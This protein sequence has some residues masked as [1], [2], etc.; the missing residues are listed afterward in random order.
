MQHPV[1]KNFFLA[2][3]A[4]D[5]RGESVTINCDLHTDARA[6]KAIEDAIIGR[7]KSIL[8]HK[9]LWNYALDNDQVTTG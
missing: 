9:A 8:H 7:S 2:D 4:A 3:D 6:V 5:G 1:C